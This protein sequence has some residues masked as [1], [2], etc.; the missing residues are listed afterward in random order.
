MTALIGRLEPSDRQL[1]SVLGRTS[2]LVKLAIALGWLVGLAFTLA[3]WPPVFIVIAALVA[4]LVL[5]EIP[6]PG[7]P[8]ASRRCG[9][10]RSGSACSTRCSRPRTPTRR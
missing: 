1:A 3:L 4:G 2:P 9:R 5:G 10:P 8:R 6:G 7:S